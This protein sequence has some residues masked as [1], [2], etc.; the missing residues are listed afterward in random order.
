MV[1]TG[2][3]RIGRIAE[4]AGTT[5]R[6]V[7]Y[8]HRLGLLAE[9]A[10][11]SNGY[12]DY[13]M[14]DAIRLM[15]IRWL[16]ESGVPLDAVGGLLGEDSSGRPTPASARP[17]EADLL[18]LIADLD[19]RRAL[20]ARRRARLAAMLDDAR[21]GRPLS[22]LPAR[23]AALFRDALEEDTATP[24]AR[25]ALQSEKDMVEALAI[26]GNAPDGFFDG[27]T[28]LL[29]DPGR[30]ARYLDLLGRWAALEHR[31]PEAARDEITEV[32]DAL[33]GLMAHWYQDGSPESG[34]AP[35]GD[36][37]PP[38][39]LGDVVPDAAQQEVVARLYRRI[40]S[41][42]PHGSAP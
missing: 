23:L 16:A 36:P 25:A 28:A 12:R 1:D 8:Y 7:R 37:H 10:R 15:R 21:H 35:D 20:L 26:S 4:L 39:L 30:R 32:T 19:E 34:T 29:E 14:P 3:M 11:R 24:A 31:D 27:F 22:P 9:P 17:V 40:H 6:T 33:T 38:P 5:T 2:A 42:P 41:A 18:A 13:T